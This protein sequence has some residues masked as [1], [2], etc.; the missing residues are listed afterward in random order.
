LPIALIAQLQFMSMHVP[1]QPDVIIHKVTLH[2][3]AG[4][5]LPSLQFPLHGGHFFL[6]TGFSGFGCF[7]VLTIYHPIFLMP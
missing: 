4:Q 6:F 7:D 2:F 3:L 5:F 1:V